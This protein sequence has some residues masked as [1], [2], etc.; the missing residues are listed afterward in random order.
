LFDSVLS[1]T[2]SIPLSLFRGV[3]KVSLYRVRHS[4]GIAR[5]A[6]VVFEWEALVKSVLYKHAY[7]FLI[8]GNILDA[9]LVWRCWIR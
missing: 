4:F 8:K 3:H 7:I 5:I 2:P 6:E 9:C 1:L